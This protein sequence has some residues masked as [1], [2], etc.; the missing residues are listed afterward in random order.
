[1]ATRLVAAAGV[2]AGAFGAAGF[3]AAGFLAVV[4]AMTVSFGIRLE[5]FG[6]GDDLDQL[7]GDLR[8]A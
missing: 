7:L 5:R 4:V 8:L 1:V 6:A 2:F 3:F